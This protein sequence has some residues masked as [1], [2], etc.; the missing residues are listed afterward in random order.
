MSKRR[1]TIKKNTPKL[2]G[3]LSCF[4][5]T[6]YLFVSVDSQKSHKLKKYVGGI[7]LAC[8]LTNQQFREEIS[9]Q[10]WISLSKILQ[11]AEFPPST[12]VGL[13]ML[14]FGYLSFASPSLIISW[15]YFPTRDNKS[16]QYRT[17]VLWL[18]TA[19]KISQNPGESRVNLIFSKKKK[20]CHFVVLISTAFF[21]LT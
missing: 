17:Y 5:N 3:K 11:T 20:H 14:A 7:S 18:F 15:N 19:I 13:Q 12:N 21:R 10:K 8:E 1:K 6:I 16:N 9:W 2:V 4:W